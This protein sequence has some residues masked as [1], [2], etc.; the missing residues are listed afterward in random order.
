MCFLVDTCVSAREDT[1]A[2]GKTC[3]HVA[4]QPDASLAIRS[5][6]SFRRS[7]KRRIDY[8]D[9]RSDESSEQARVRNL[10]AEIKRGQLSA[11]RPC[12]PVAAV[13]WVRAVSAC[14]GG[15]RGVSSGF[16]RILYI[17]GVRILNS[18]TVAKLGSGVSLLSSC[19]C[20]H[21]G[22]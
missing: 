21:R 10:P 2:F 15:A 20:V 8:R 22:C 16:C 9:P 4:E 12:L 17:I 7:A 5:Q 11:L 3:G 14:A 13:Y 18:S 19:R 6:D 1:A